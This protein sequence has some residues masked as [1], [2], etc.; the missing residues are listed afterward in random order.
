MRIAYGTNGFANHRLEDALEVIAELG[1]DGVALTLDHH[2]LDPFAGDLPRRVAEVRGRLERLGLSV[3][4][5]T[6]ARYLLDPRRKHHPTL[7]SDDVE[8]RVDFLERAVR[9][10]AGLGA[11]VVSFWSGIRPSDVDSELA[12]RRMTDGLARVLEEAARCGVLL[13]L[14]PEPG[15]F[16]ER[17]DDALAVRAALGNPRNLGVTLDVGHCVAVE[18]ESAADCARRLGELLVHVQLDDMRPGVHEH[19]EFGQGELDLPGTLAALSEAGY[20]GQAAVELPRHSHAAPEVAR[21]ARTAIGAA[22]WLADALAAIAEDPARVAALFPA[23]GR[24]VGR[25]PLR[26]DDPLGLVHGTADDR[27]RGR[28]LAVLA[29]TVKPAALAEE[30]SALYRYGDDA[31]RRAVLRS[32]SELDGSG[33]GGS[34]LVET[35]LELVGDAL[36]TNDVR[37]VAAALGPF[38]ARHLDEHTWRHGVLKCLFTEVPLA[39]VAGWRRRRD[40]E[41]RRMV[42]AFADER[43]AAGRPVPEDARA[44]LES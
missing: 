36:R 12:W 37:L 28:M 14:E 10:A 20:T 39:A 17:V 23:A 34:D 3:A 43:R 40:A 26:A 11:E 27:A 1:Y 15:M 44:L 41:L 35:G 32:L 18:T 5:E 8:R 7:V 38:A 9:V 13:G 24:H 33:P 19:L 31:E 29:R 22:G 25:G 4:V 2:H 16:V 42:G 6:G 30:V 21:R